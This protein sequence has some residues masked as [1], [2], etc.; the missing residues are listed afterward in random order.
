TGVSIPCSA[1]DTYNSCS[2]KLAE[3]LR[4]SGYDYVSSYCD[5]ENPNPGFFSPDTISRHGY[6]TIH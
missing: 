1:A 5:I 2:D 4:R 6:I 3:E